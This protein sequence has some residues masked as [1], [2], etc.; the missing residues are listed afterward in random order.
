[1]DRWVHIWRTPLTPLWITK[2]GR[3]FNGIMDHAVGLGYGE[4]G[5]L[6]TWVQFK[7]TGTRRSDCRC[8]LNR[9][10]E[11][12]LASSSGQLSH[13]LSISNTGQLRPALTHF[14]QLVFFYFHAP[15]TLLLLSFSLLICICCPLS[16]P[17]WYVVSFSTA[18]RFILISTGTWYEGVKRSVVSLHIFWMQLRI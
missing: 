13:Q 4:W 8:T 7:W 11:V 2:R 5:W 10:F 17:A 6:L 1:M 18:V 15:N 14:I 16:F 12:D 3:V 9:C